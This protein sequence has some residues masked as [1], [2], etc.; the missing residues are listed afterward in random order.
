MYLFISRALCVWLK[1]LQHLS[2]KS[3]SKKDDS[4]NISYLVGGIKMFLFFIIF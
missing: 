3:V 1:K 4:K 2:E